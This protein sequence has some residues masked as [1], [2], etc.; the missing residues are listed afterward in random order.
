MQK[1]IKSVTAKIGE[2]KHPNKQA[3]TKANTMNTNHTLT[4]NSNP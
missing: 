3:T 2:E 4:Y 1:D